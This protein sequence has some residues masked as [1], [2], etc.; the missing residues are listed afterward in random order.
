MVRAKGALCLAR[1]AEL[2][3]V[4]AQRGMGTPARLREEGSVDALVAL[5]ARPS[6][7]TLELPG[8]A[9]E[10]RSL[11]Y[12]ACSGAQGHQS[13]PCGSCPPASWK[14]HSSPPELP[15]STTA[16]PLSWGW[17]P[18]VGT[19]ASLR[20]L[21]LRKT[22]TRPGWARVP[23]GPP[24]PDCLPRPAQDIAYLAH[25]CHLAVGGRTHP[26]AFSCTGLQV[27]MVVTQRVE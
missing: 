7:A 12:A 6:G 15:T 14:H 17:A 10:P 11:V 19:V 27:G 8:R 3:V 4:R 25:L 20:T 22:S 1:V 5:V 24:V 16:W 26:A 21:H 18:R 9:L 2:L 13:R 23:S